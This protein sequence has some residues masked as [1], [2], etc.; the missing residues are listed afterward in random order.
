MAEQRRIGYRWNLRQLM[1]QRNLWKTT[2]LLPLLKARNINL[3]NAQ[4]HRLVTGTPGA[5]SRPDL[6]STLRHPRMHAQRPVRALRA[7]ARR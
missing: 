5:H 1:A 6:R 3:S 7:D 4:V 2:E